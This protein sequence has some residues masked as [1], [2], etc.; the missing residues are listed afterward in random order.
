M[1]LNASGGRSEMAP[2]FFRTTSNEQWARSAPWSKESGTETS[3]LLA[4]T[5][6]KAAAAEER[7]EAQP[8]FA[9]I[10]IA[11]MEEYNLRG[12]ESAKKAGK[13]FSPSYLM[14]GKISKRITEY[15]ERN[16]ISPS[17][18]PSKGSGEGESFHKQ[19]QK[20]PGMIQGTTTNRQRVCFCYAPQ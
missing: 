18:L 10:V 15:E 13:T 12:K 8:T 7:N 5:A 14:I 2:S 17:V 9:Q 20:I 4:L 1:R 3:R 6:A 16:N 11:V 19:L